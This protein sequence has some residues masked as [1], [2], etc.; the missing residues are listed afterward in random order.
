MAGNGPAP[1]DPGTRRR[2]NVAVGKT[3]L[4]SN[5]RDGEMPVWPLRTVTRVTAN[6]LNQADLSESDRA[7]PIGQDAVR[8]E[9]REAEVWERL[10]RSPQAVAWERSGAHL[11]VA[12][13]VR[14]FVQAEGGD[15]KAAAE[16]RQ[17][18]DRL[19]LNPKAMRSLLWEVT[20]D[21]VAAKREE[22]VPSKAASKRAQLKIVG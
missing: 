19:G 7:I 11:D 16:A 15:M 1:K 18:S 22:S 10:W 20:D 9:A 3:L 5:G 21:E 13:Y 2:R 8:D 4:P 12:L 14:L 6:L 17:W